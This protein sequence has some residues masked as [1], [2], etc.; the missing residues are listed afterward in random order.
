MV[1][2]AVVT[3][4]A[5]AVVTAVAKRKKVDA[6]ATVTNQRNSLYNNKV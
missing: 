5:T 4:A 2:I 1:A 6:A 3:A